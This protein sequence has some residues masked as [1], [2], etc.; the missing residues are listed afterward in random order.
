MNDLW[1]TFNVKEDLLPKVKIGSI[2]TAYVPG[3]AKTVQLKIDYMAAQA[4]SR[5]LV[6]HQNARRF[7]H[8]HIRSKGTSGKTRSQACVR[9]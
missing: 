7:R 9:E 6:G 1:V 3:L 2:L 4:E 5:D 8:P